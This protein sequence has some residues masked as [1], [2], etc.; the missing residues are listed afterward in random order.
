MTKK[1]GLPPDGKIGRS[2]WESQKHLEK[3]LGIPQ[4]EGKLSYQNL[5]KFVILN[6][7]F[8]E[9]LFLSIRLN[10]RKFPFF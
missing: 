1:E 6:Q 2:L 8:L 5:E 9:R 7:R 3:H 10:Y 4:T